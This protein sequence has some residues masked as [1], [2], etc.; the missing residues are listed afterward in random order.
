[1]R[2][3]PVG[4]IPQQMTALPKVRDLT[5]TSP[6]LV[7]DLQPDVFPS[8]VTICFSERRIT[9]ADG[10]IVTFVINDKIKENKITN[11]WCGVPLLPLAKCLSS[12]T[13]ADY[14]WHFDTSFM[15]TPIEK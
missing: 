13:G 4:H 7:F 11:L 10:L 6:P 5:I 9:K 3:K 12:S 15:S 14:I 8:M 2:H 1:M